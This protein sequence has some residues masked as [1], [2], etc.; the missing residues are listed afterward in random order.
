MSFATPPP[1]EQPADSTIGNNQVVAG[2]IAEK[3]TSN[4]AVV[5]WQTTETAPSIL[6]YGT[7]PGDL[8]QRLQR[9]WNTTTHEVSLKKL[10]PGTAYYLEILQPD[11]ISAASG[12]FT[13]EPLGYA[14]QNT[15]RITNGPLFEQIKTD[16]TTIAWSTNLPS[17]SL[18]RYGTDPYNLDQTAKA[19]WTPTTH[20]VVL[21]HLQP[22]THYYFTIE[23]T[24][25]APAAGEQPPG[26]I[27]P[28]VYAFRTLARGQQAVNIGP[29]R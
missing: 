3:V 22:D 13:T 19:P 28:Q 18:I 23:S 29:R 6:V 25:P 16:S 12:Q 7:A 14:R 24:Q 4:S 17:S 27:A 1:P 15:V 9:P 8:H 20:R 2:P 10:Q 21:H 11:G 5:W 26:P